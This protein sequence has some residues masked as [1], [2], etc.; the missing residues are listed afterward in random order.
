MVWVL[1]LDGF[2]QSG[3][4]LV[5]LDGACFAGESWPYKFSLVLLSHIPIIVFT[6][7]TKYFIVLLSNYVGT[8][9]S[10]DC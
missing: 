3:V 8:K 4:V 6:V 2:Y 7:I 10:R 1:S 9:P 5:A